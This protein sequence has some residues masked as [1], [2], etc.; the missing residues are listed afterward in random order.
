MISVPAAVAKTGPAGD[1]QA[2]PLDPAIVMRI[3]G[4]LKA[5]RTQLAAV[6]AEV[7]AWALR[8]SSLRF[9]HGQRFA[10]AHLTDSTAHGV[11]VLGKKAHGFRA[12]FAR[13][14]PGGVD[15]A[16]PLWRA[17]IRASKGRGAAQVGFIRSYI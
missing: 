10:F 15:I 17:W 2:L 7:R 6:Q 11:V 12:C 16:M 9:K 13:W 3:E 1:D 4:V 14:T 5:Q 8:M